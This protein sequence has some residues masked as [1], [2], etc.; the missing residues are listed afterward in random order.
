MQEKEE[1]IQKEYKN[2]IKNL[3]DVDA[4]ILN[5]MDGTILEMARIKIELDDLHEIV[6]ETGIIKVHPE[7]PSVQK[8]IPAAK[9]LV[10]HRANYLNYASKLA[11][12][13]GKDLI[14]EDD[15]G[16]DEFE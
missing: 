6:N 4:A 16:L 15:L 8:E 12:I 9:M 10:R 14:E 3:Q 7:D 5:V 13:L 2:T 1:R 11:S